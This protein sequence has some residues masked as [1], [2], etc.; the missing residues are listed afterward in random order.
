M[1]AAHR[2]DLARMAAMG[3]PIVNHG[4]DFAALHWR[5]SAP[6]MPR[7]QQQDPLSARDRLLQRAVDRRPGP[8]EAVSMKVENPI[9][10]DPS[11]SDR[12]IPAAVERRL[13]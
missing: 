4:T 9:N 1:R 5:F 3:Q 6:F 13:M 8:I 2:G 12:S 7:H 10:L 11:R